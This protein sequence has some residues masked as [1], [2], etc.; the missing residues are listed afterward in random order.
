ML[1]QTPKQ[2]HAIVRASNH[3]LP[4]LCSSHLCNVLIEQQSL[5]TWHESKEV[6]ARRVLNI[7][8]AVGA[9]TILQMAISFPSR[10]LLCCTKYADQSTASVII[11]SVPGLAMPLKL[12]HQI[13]RRTLN[14]E[15]SLERPTTYN[16]SLLKIQRTA[17]PI[18]AHY[19]IITSL[20]GPS[21]C[22]NL[23]RHPITKD[24][25]ALRK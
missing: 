18:G 8:A 24:A 21:Q 23:F 12:H 6:R 22:R 19:S 14:A 2:C 20:K 1:N 17:I 13:K 10:A 25:W 11:F 3:S 5:N 16:S 15:L 7:L 9:L 4:K